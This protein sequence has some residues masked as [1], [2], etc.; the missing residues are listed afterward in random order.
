MYREI[1]TECRSIAF[2]VYSSSRE[3]RNFTDSADDKLYFLVGL[4]FVA[5][6]LTLLASEWTEENLLDVRTLNVDRSGWFIAIKVQ[7]SV[8]LIS[9][10]LMS[11]QNFFR[12]PPDEI[13]SNYETNYKA[14]LRTYLQEWNTRINNAK[15]PNRQKGKRANKKDRVKI[16]IADNECMW[17][18][19]YIPEH[20]RMPFDED[21]IARHLKHLTQVQENNPDE[22]GNAFQVHLY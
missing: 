5:L 16:S 21:M 13:F 12:K 6:L 20:L 14:A 17:L 22:D 9:I 15:V 3:E 1:L 18:E 19:I 4:A 11:I 8:L 7:V 2:T 10:F